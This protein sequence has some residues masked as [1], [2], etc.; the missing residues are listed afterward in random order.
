MG[1]ILERKLNE[2]II[3]SLDGI[4]LA[5][6]AIVRKMWQRRF[7]ILIDAPE[8]VAI[9]RGQRIKPEFDKLPK[10]DKER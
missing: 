8:N 4:E 10:V 7:H 1:L 3:I 5:R 6:F 9:T 2:E